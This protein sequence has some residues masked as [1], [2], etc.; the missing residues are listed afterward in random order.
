MTRADVKLSDE[1]SLQHSIKIRIMVAVLTHLDHLYMI[2][3]SFRMNLIG[4][5]NEFLI[6]IKYRRFPNM[7][8]EY[9]LSTTR[10][11]QVDYTVL[12]RFGCDGDRM[13][14]PYYSNYEMGQLLFPSCNVNDTSFID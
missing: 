6:I 2:N 11:T 13:L 8:L 14:G 4:N 5:D 10:N 12:L 9:Y 3:Y 1:N 7:S